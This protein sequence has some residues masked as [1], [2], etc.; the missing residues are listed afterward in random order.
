VPGASPGVAPGQPAPVTVPVAVLAV[1]A[2]LAVADV[3]RLTA[4]CAGS[5]VSLV[6]Y[7]QRPSGETARP[8]A[9]SPRGTRPT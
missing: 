3:R 2:V 7:S 5:P 1:L 8:T 9:A 6:A 4:C